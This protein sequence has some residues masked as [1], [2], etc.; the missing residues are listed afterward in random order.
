MTQSILSVYEDTI[1]KLNVVV[2][3][4]LSVN[5]SVITQMRFTWL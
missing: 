3:T 1:S 4:Q 2:M 5:L